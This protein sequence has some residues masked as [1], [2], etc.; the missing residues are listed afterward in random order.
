VITVLVVNV[1]GVVMNDG[2]VGIDG[3]GCLVITTLDGNHTGTVSVG[4]M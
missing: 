2:I 3:I 1:N 4:G